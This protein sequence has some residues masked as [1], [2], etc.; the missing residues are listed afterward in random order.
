MQH[1]VKTRSRKEGQSRKSNT[2]L[3]GR[4][5]IQSTYASLSSSLSMRAARSGKPPPL[6]GQPIRL[7]SSPSPVGLRFIFTTL[8]LSI[9]FP[10]P[11]RRDRICARELLADKRSKNTKSRLNNF[12]RKNQ[13]TLLSTLY[14][15]MPLTRLTS[16]KCIG[17]HL[18]PLTYL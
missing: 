14:M 10:L 18:S 4:P 11:S 8:P 12:T 5:K 16:Y 3:R 7:P 1:A 9:C 15:V 6:D 13:F 17:D 2:F